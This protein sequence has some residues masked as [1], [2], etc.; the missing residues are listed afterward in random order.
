MRAA[1][2]A[3]RFRASACRTVVMVSALA[4]KTEMWMVAFRSRGVAPLRIRDLRWA[5]RLPGVAHTTEP[6]P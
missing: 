2:S 4:E 5:A 6:P 3:C 1:G